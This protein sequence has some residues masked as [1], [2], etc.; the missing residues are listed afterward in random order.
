MS[1]MQASSTQLFFIPIFLYP[2]W[3]IVEGVRRLFFSNLAHVP[4]P[5]LAALT[6]WYEFYY[7]VV[8]PGR[9]VWKIKDLHA[10]YGKLHTLPPSIMI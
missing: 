5:R 2:I 7:D 3:L 8:Q 4:G 6:S 10:E 9:Y 1:D